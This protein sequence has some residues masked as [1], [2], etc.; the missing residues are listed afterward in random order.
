VRALKSRT[1]QVAAASLVCYV[2]VTVFIGRHV[3]DHLATGIANDAGNRGLRALLEV[4]LRIG[5]PT[6]S[7]VPREACRLEGVSPCGPIT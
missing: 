7:G 2:A 6:R 4:T 3:L 5:M 1:W